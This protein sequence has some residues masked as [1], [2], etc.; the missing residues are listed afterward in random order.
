M[1]PSALIVD[2]DG[3]VADN[4]HREHFLHQS[5]KDWKSFYAACA[6]DK[7]KVHVIQ[8]VIH[9]AKNVGYVPIFVTGRTESYRHDTAQ[10][11]F[12]HAPLLGGSPLFMRPETD[13]RSDDVV[14]E[15]IYRKE[16]APYYR[17]KLA[18][19]DR[20]RVVA[21]WRRLGIECWQVAEGPA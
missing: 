2:I 11:L 9:L 6:D 5:P 8:A 21:L 16:I 14:K 7:P 15:E 12:D 19:D 4:T 13:F 20:A 17:V 1:K 3:T 10:W 18:I